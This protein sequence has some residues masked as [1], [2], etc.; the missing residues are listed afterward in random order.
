MVECPYC[1]A[2]FDV[3]WD[4]TDYDDHVADCQ[5]EEVMEPTNRNRP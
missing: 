3:R 4:S 2:L 5:L 1:G